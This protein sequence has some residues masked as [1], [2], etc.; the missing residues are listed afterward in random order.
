[1]SAASTGGRQIRLPTPP[2]R[3]PRRAGEFIQR[4]TPSP[5]AVPVLFRIKLRPTTGVE[6]S[7]EKNTFYPPGR[8]TIWKKTRVN[9]PRLAEF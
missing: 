3:L 7:F 1:L 9:A 5:A 8:N 2:N 4:K 6:L